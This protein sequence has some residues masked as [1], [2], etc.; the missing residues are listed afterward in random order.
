MPDFLFPPRRRDVFL[1]AEPPVE[2]SALMR[3]CGAARLA[4]LDLL[5]GRLG[6]ADEARE[7]A[8]LPLGVPGPRDDWRRL[9]D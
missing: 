3:L 5:A 8:S 7:P 2:A 4:G 9:E 1:F 6:W